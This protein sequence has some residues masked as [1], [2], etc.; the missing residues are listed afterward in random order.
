V[1]VS[2]AGAD[3]AAIVAVD[4]GFKLVG[5]NVGSWVYDFQATNL[6]DGD[7][8]SASSSD[9]VAFITEEG[10]KVHPGQGRTG[11]ENGPT[12]TAS[13]GLDTV[14]GLQ[15]TGDLQ[16]PSGE[17]GLLFEKKVQA[18]AVETLDANAAFIREEVRT[19]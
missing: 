3:G 10:L 11:P 9:V 2:R 16:M 6:A 12:T 1:W 4:G 15:Q 18:K 19:R 14:A 17:L 5:A 13:N 7:T 8:V